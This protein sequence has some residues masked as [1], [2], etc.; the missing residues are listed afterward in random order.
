[1]GLAPKADTLRPLSR[2]RTGFWG[3]KQADGS[4]EETGSRNNTGLAYKH[5][6]RLANSQPIASSLGP[7]PLGCY[8]VGAFFMALQKGLLI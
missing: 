2:Q 7:A 4:H 1:M 8:Q 5:H 6:K 3:V